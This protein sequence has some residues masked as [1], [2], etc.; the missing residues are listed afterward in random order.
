MLEKMEFY[1]ARSFTVMSLKQQNDMKLQRKVR[2]TL[3]SGRATL[4]GGAGPQA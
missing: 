1:E 4:A 2:A 3:R